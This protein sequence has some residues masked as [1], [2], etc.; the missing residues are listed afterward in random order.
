MVSTYAKMAHSAG[1]IT[2]FSEGLDRLAE[3]HSPLLVHCAAGKD[4]TGLFVY[5]LHHILGVSSTDAIADYLLTNDAVNLQGIA[6]QASVR[7]AEKIGRIFSVEVLMPMV[8]VDKL[9]LQSA[10]SEIQRIDGSLDNYLEH[11]LGIGRA[12]REAIR[13]QLIVRH[14]LAARA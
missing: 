5:L 14:A 6:E 7:F 3:G 12:K 9:Y 1:H 2:A 11:T 4:R 8:V 10:L 13:E